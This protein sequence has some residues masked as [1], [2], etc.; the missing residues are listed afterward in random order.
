MKFR[1]SHK[2]WK[3][4]DSAAD[5][6]LV[7]GIEYDYE[8]KRAGLW[9]RWFTQGI[10]TYWLANNGEGGKLRLTPEEYDHWLPYIPFG[11]KQK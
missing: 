8:N 4:V 9:I 1:D 7:E 10:S 3:H 6:I 11:E 5:F 2:F